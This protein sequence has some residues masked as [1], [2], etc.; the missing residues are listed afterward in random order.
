MWGEWAD[1]DKETE[2][3]RRGEAERLRHRQSVVMI[4]MGAVSV[5]E[6][7]WLCR[8]TVMPSSP[9]ATLLVSLN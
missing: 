6:L 4:G 1:R 2:T 3:E 7:G 8:V 5:C 9:D